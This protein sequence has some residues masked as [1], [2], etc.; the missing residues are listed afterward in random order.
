MESFFGP[1][2]ALRNEADESD[3]IEQVINHI[4]TEDDPA[5]LV[6]IVLCWEGVATSANHCSYSA[7]KKLRSTGWTI[8]KQSQR[9]E[10]RAKREL[11]LRLMAM[12]YPDASP[13]S[14]AKYAI[15]FANYLQMSDREFAQVERIRLT[16]VGSRKAIRLSGTEQ[17]A[18]DSD[19]SRT[20]DCSS[21]SIETEIEAASEEMSSLRRS[22]RSRKPPAQTQVEV[23][24]RKKPRSIPRMAGAASRVEDFF[25]ATLPSVTNACIDTLELLAAG[26]TV[27]PYAGSR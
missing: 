14:I 12:Q 26:K 5:K 6:R 17:P 25:W 27:H 1:R 3:F 21:D 24:P 20:S 9:P 13:T 19:S 8:V 16:N 11:L 15:N 23:Q 7:L 22:S 2:L 4:S 10:D 18:E